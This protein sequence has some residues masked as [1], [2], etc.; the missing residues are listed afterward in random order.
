M[1]VRS[2][3]HQGFTLVELLV[4]MGIIS[5]LMAVALP[6]LV[7]A[8]EAAR[9]TVCL[10][11]CSQL[12][13]A[14]LLYLNDNKQTLP[15]ACNANSPESPL[16]PRATGLPPGTSI[17]PDTHVLATAAVLLEPYV[18]SSGD[19]WRCPSAPNESFVMTGD[20]PFA[21]SAN[22]D[23]FKPNYSFMATKDLVFSIPAM[24]YNDVSR[25]R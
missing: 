7:K 5:V 15:D 6:S 10:S 1:S 17:G 13:K 9:R 19:V 25:F 16:S 20:H 3:F 22:A 8:R 11:N 24:D 4:V 23:A 21:G 12:T 14:V 2:R 18:G